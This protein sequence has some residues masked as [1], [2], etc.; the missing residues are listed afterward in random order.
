MTIQSTCRAVRAPLALRARFISATRP[1]LMLGTAL[2]CSIAIMA[3]APGTAW[4]GDEC[5]D[6]IGGTITCTATSGVGNP[7]PNGIGYVGDAGEDITVVL[8]GAPGSAVNVDSG[9][10]NGVTVINVGGYDADLVI[11]SGATVVSTANGVRARGYATGSDAYVYNAGSVTGGTRGEFA[12][13]SNA[14]ATVINTGSVA[15][16]GASNGQGV[17]IGVQANSYGVLGVSTVSN[18]GLVTVT[19]ASNDITRGLEAG[20]TAGT[21]SIYNAGAVDVSAVAGGSLIGVGVFSGTYA[22]VTTTVDGT[23]DLFTA[24]TGYAYGIYAHAYTGD[25]VINAAGA[26]TV[27]TAGSG[28]GISA[29]GGTTVYI[30]AGD[31]T[32]TGINGAAVRGSAAGLVEIIANGDITATGN[33]VEGVAAY[34]N[35]GIE[36][37]ALG[38]ISTAGTDAEGI[39]GRGYNSADVTILAAGITTTGLNSEGVYAV[40]NGNIDVT[41]NGLISTVG[42]NSYGVLARS[43]GAGEVYVSAYDVTTTG[44]NSEG[45]WAFGNNA[46]TVIATGDVITEGAYSTGLYAGSYGAGLVTVD[47]ATVSTTGF[48]SDAIFANSNSGSVAVSF[49]SLTTTGAGSDGVQALAETGVSVIGAGPVDA[50]GMGVYAQTTNGYAYVSVE[51]VTAYG[52]GVRVIA[53][54]GYATVETGAIDVNGSFGIQANG[55]AE[56]SVTVTGDIAVDTGEGGAT[57]VYAES[58]SG[59]ASIIV[60]GDTV[61]TSPGAAIGVDGDGFDGT[62]VE[63]NGDLTVT[64]YGSTATGVQAT[65]DTGLIDIDVT[66]DVT[67]SGSTTTFGIQAVFYNGA[68]EPQ[69]VEIDVTGSVGAYSAIGV[70]YGVRAINAETASIDVSGAVTAEGLVATGVQVFANGDFDI[71]AGSISAEGTLDGAGILGYSD[72]GIA[73][74]DVDGT[75]LVTGDN[76]EGIDVRADGVV[77]TVGGDVTTDGVASEG[78]RA[79]AVNDGGDIYAS[80]A[81]ITTEG[82]QSTAIMAYA[83]DDVTV[84]AS[85]DISTQGANSAGIIAISRLGLIVIDVQDV[86]TTG[87]GSTAISAQNGSGV[88]IDAVDITAT[89]AFASGV[90][91]NTFYGAADIDVGDVTAGFFGIIAYAL[92]GVTIEAGDV[93]AGGIGVRAVAG[94]GY[95]TVSTGAIDADGAFG[96][97]ANGATGVSVSV[98]GDISVSPGEGGATGVY[99]QSDSGPTSII[100]V[101]DTVVEASGDATGVYGFSY[102]GGVLVDVTG[103]ISATST[104]AS[105]YGVVGYAYYGDVMIEVSGAITADAVTDAFGV[106]VSFG[107]PYVDYYYYYNRGQ[108]AVVSGPVT[109]ALGDPQTVT[110]TVGG[111]IIA[112]ADYGVAAGVRVTADDD[113][114]VETADIT[115]TADTGSAFGLDLDSNYG[116]VSATVDGDLSIS[117]PGGSS[118]AFGMDLSA[119][120]AIDVAMTGDID[121]QGGWAAYGVLAQGG[122]DVSVDIDGAITVDAQGNATGVRAES[123][124]GSA[125]AYV[126]DVDVFAYGTAVAVSVVGQYGAT[127]VST[128]QVISSG[129]GVGARSNLGA[130]SA[131]VVD[132]T[133]GS[134][135]VWA[136]TNSGD[137]TVIATGEI[138]SGGAGLSAWTGSG[139]AS[140]TNDGSVVTSG[141]YAYGIRATTTFGD[142]N[143]DSDGTVETNGDAAYGIVARTSTG[144]IA[145]SFTDVR[146]FGSAPPTGYSGEYGEGYL[147]YG[148]ASHGIV[149]ESDYGQVII[150]GGD[151][152]AGGRG[153]EG[154]IASGQG[155]VLIDVGT[156]QTQGYLLVA[157]NDGYS[158]VFYDTST[159][160]IGID[161]MVHGGDLSIYADA[162][163]T[164]GDFATGILA[165]GAAINVYDYSGYDARP[166]GSLITLS[167]DVLVDVG[168]VQTLGDNANGIEAFNAGGQVVVLAEGVYTFGDYSTGIYA[169]A[170]AATDAVSGGLLIGD[171]S[172]AADTVHTYGDASTGVFASSN[173]GDAS[174]DAVDVLTFGDQARGVV[175]TAGGAYDGALETFVFGD[176]NVIVDSVATHGDGALAVDAYAQLG[177]VSILAGDVYTGGDDADGLWGHASGDVAIE[178]DNVVATGDYASGVLGVSYNGDV[179]VLVENVGVYG[180]GA[181]AIMVSANSGEGGSQDT[182]V[183]VT[184]IVS[185]F[186]GSGIVAD[187]S[188]YSSITIDHGL[189]A[190]A[191]AAIVSTAGYATIIEN[192]G[193]FIYGGSGL[194]IQVNGAFAQISN[195]GVI[196]GRVDLTEGADL[197]YNDGIFEA[198]GTSAFGGGADRFENDGELR[199][200][201]LSGPAS[202]TSFTGLE[203]FDN[204]SLVTGVDGQAGDVLSL[205]GATFNGGAGSE[206]ALDVQFGGPGSIADR[207]VIGQATGVTNIVPNAVLA[208]T[209]GVLNLAGILVVDS[210]FASQTGAE[211]T[212]A[213]VDTGFVE[214]SLRFDAPTDNWLIVGLPD[215]SVFRILALPG[216][217]QDF[218]QRSS[219]AVNSRWQES[220]DADT[221]AGQASAGPD[222][223]SGRSEGWE[224]WMQAHGGDEGFED[225][226]TFSIGGSVFVENQS[227]NSDW[228]GFQFGAD[229]RT[230]DFTWGLTGGFVQQETTFEVG[231]ESFDIEGWNAGA[232]ASW[233]SG[234]LFLN[235]LV[236]GDFNTVDANLTAVGDMETFDASSFGL[237]GELGYRLAGDA[238][239]VE[240]VASLAWT[241]TRIDSFTASGATLDFEDADSLVGKAGM[242]VGWTVGSGDVVLVPAI[243]VFAIEEFE[244][245]NAMTFTTGATSFAV[246]DTPPGA[247]GKVEFGVTAQTFYGLE[248]YVRGEVNFGDEADGGAVRLGARW[249]W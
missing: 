141:D 175:V 244:G 236:K 122:G 134:D 64:S 143:V 54:T 226:E 199:F 27:T 35:T 16:I 234:G 44:D 32:V 191:Y 145:I 83:N 161:A 140:V 151:V 242:R 164:A 12:S 163:Y 129:V 214:Y 59:L 171:A 19:G 95:V 31:V 150:E 98:T 213:T 159:G 53:N 196:Y 207:I 174:V 138:I 210:A 103:S 56:V 204:T 131:T 105:A 21:A 61:V 190:G 55:G 215:T 241:T 112:H 24:G 125:Y 108:Q 6:D 183:T 33:S 114:T 118:F 4:A 154:I 60:N 139:D 113:I 84:I 43:F 126:V 221:G 124:Y 235:G 99:A 8:S 239:F 200:S 202:T 172:V 37:S 194:A 176:A 1:S 177:D 245:E 81:G 205:A 117:A 3:G 152:F 157:G 46:V 107:E 146:T 71:S 189:V 41:T 247:Y 120:G 18:T 9:G 58:G 178:V 86:T 188:G 11:E 133:A 100:I 73:T 34:S 180:Y 130:A 222:G 23:I 38:A 195:G 238:W 94:D 231:G 82:A 227:H 78:I 166:E 39:R 170:M 28:T 20:A 68:L 217:M 169:I 187:A 218:W 132:V 47:A 79:Y 158:S 15:V 165:I 10:F 42:D 181:D 119:G 147:E 14:S 88:F 212:M 97:Q 106:L 67:V 127:A 243:G 136:I 233:M 142:V 75:I 89:G 17:A 137:A 51:D 85:G 69:T 110:V 193:G 93:D 7:Y 230:G 49:D 237:Q 57:G 48:N 216:A 203:T 87:D 246:A 76:V 155:A 160:A 123:Q 179:Q 22:G 232:Y 25:V 5:G 116:D 101:G 30:S 29:V 26:V 162:V 249:R 65:T 104:G 211:F 2:G 153:S 40:G 206:L 111:P 223:A 52:L 219:V 186:S 228:R 77:I 240:P 248:G 168:I 13:A 135:A 182:G 36:I 45:V 72:G 70:A 62:Y 201:G 149:A 80:V 102:D 198:Y 63:I 91:V 167:G 109:A 192:D 144:D 148:Q 156:V 197:F 224:M 184:G 220:R 185:S 96:I 115:A 66:G 173:G 121:A 92:D 208:A 229:N 50:A 90:A 128:G 209:P 225:F 74:F